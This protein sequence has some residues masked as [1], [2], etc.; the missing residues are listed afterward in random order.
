MADRVI[1]FSDGHVARVE[2]NAEKAAPSA[3][4]W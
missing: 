4:S 1:Y 3:L 2:A